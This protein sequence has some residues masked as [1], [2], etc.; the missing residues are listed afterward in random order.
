M[1]FKLLCDGVALKPTTMTLQLRTRLRAQTNAERLRCKRR[2]KT[3][4]IPAYA[5]NQYTSTNSLLCYEKSRKFESIQA[6][7]KPYL[8]ETH[9]DSLRGDLLW[10]ISSPRHIFNPYVYLLLTPISKTSQPIHRIRCI[11]L[12]GEDLLDVFATRMKTSC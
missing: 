8:R 11:A 2:E 9:T 4:K 10:D 7:E 3:K 12:I 6:E 1:C 5:V